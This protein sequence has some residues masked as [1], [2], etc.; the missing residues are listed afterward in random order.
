MWPSSP[1]FLALGMNHRTAPVG[2]R[3]RLAL[4]RPALEKASRE[5]LGLNGVQEALFLSTCNRVELYVATEEENLCREALVEWMARVGGL[6]RGEIEPCL[7]DHRG[8]NAIRHLFRVASSLDSM[9]VGE[10]QILGQVK[11]AFGLAQSTES[12]GPLLYPLL[13]QAI[14]VAR[15]VRNETEIGKHAVSVSFAAVE[16]ARKIFGGLQGRVVFLIGAGKM[17]EL[18]AKHLQVQGASRL[19]VTNRTW[20]RAQA[21]ADLLRAEALLFDRVDDGLTQADVVITSTDS[22]EP[23]INKAR[24]QPLLSLRRHRPLFFVDIAVPRDVEAAVNDLPNIYLYDIDDLKQVVGANLKE[25]QREAV[26]AEGLVER[27][28]ERFLAWFRDQA[29]VPT[30]VS[31]RE[32]LEMIRQQELAKTVSRLGEVSPETRRV[33]EAMSAAIVNKILHLPIVKLREASRL[34]DGQLVPL[35][36]E[37][38]GLDPEAPGSDEPRE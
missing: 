19:L 28:V 12:I 27:E 24:L 33:M 32:R 9:I 4:P 3:E 13:T 37:L 20:E 1:S 21:L 35:V 38:F 26:R 6:T 23:L 31:L 7:Y 22:P 16:L 5:L 8:P 34:G 29:V 14:I 11:D 10:P 30:I 18:A 17:G 25:R 15:R 2:L 36:R